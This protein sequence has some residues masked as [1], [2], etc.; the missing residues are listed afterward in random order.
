M[1]TG[2][3]ICSLKNVSPQ[4]FL[5]SSIIFLK[6]KMK[7]HKIAKNRY[8]NECYKIDQD[9][10][11]HVNNM[12]SSISIYSKSCSHVKGF[13]KLILILCSIVSFYYYTSSNKI[14]QDNC[15]NFHV[16]V[17]FCSVSMTFPNLENE[18]I[19]SMFSMVSRY[20]GNPEL[21]SLKKNIL[22]CSF[23]T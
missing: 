11:G 22:P 7:N 2:I 10:T 20:R 21:S 9:Q 18:K 6:K 23:S 19:N 5:F 14:F 12:G 13:H 17:H 8:K 1:S 15:F 3:D 16:S 4:M